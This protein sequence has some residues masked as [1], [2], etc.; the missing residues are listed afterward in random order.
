MDIITKKHKNLSPDIPQGE[1]PSAYNYSSNINPNFQGYMNPNQPN[2]YTPNQIY[3]PSINYEKLK[4]ESESKPKEPTKEV[5]KT[6]KITLRFIVK[7]DILFVIMTLALS[8]GM[9]FLLISV[10]EIGQDSVNIAMAATMS[11]LISSFMFSYFKEPFKIGFRWDNADLLDMLK[12]VLLGIALVL[13]N[14]FAF[15]QLVEASVF[16][17][18]ETLL[19]ASFVTIQAIAEELTFSLFLQSLAVANSKKR[20]QLVLF[21]LG[22]AGLFAIYHY[23]VYGFGW[24][25]LQLAVF[26]IILAYIYT[27]SKRISIPM[28]IHLINNVIPLIMFIVNNGGL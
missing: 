8:F 1:L 22:N 17:S 19:N 12:W 5:K 7:Y 27:K 28:L 11:A 23:I 16:A 14:S 24:V 25:L 20:Y 2:Y 21:T 15:S 18:N 4:A 10:N 3:Q 6:Y 26:R 13:A 9:M